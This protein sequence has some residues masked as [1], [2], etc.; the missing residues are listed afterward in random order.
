MEV[1][2]NIAFS[3]LRATFCMMYR[4]EYAS[5]IIVINSNESKTYTTTQKMII[6]PDDQSRLANV[7]GLKWVTEDSSF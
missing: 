1:F 3:Q 2:N 5:I 7:D 6:N 4:K